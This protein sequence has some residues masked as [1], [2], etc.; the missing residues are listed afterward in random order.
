MKE[1]TLQDIWDKLV[2]MD[3]R[4]DRLEQRMD[5]L[6]QRVTILEERVVSIIEMLVGHDHLIKQLVTRDEF[7]AFKESNASQHDAM[8]RG[9]DHLEKEF[10]S[11]NR[12]QVRLQGRM[13]RAES[14]IHELQA[15]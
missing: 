1:I 7:E 5:K 3:E 13:D 8:A 12:G 2:T 14:A 11:F 9:L 6:E 15:V 10:A 4:M